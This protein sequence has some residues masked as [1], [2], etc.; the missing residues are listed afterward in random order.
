MNMLAVTIVGSL[1]MDMV[2]RVTHLPAFGETILGRDYHI[3]PGGKGANQAVAAARLGGTVHMV[4]RVGQDSNGRI[5]CSNLSAE[6]ID[7]E[8]VEVDAKSPSGVAMI[9]LDEAGQNTIVVAPG[10]NMTL[11]PENLSR[12]FERIVSM[13]ALILQLESPL[14]CV[15]EAARLGRARHAKVVLNPAPARTLPDEIYKNID[16]LVPN[17]T[18]TNLM[19]GL[20]VNTLEQAETAARQLIDMGAGEVVLTLG[21]RGALVVE[22]GK[23]ALHVPPH[24]VHVVDTTAA[25]DAFVAGLAIGLAEGLALPEATR[26]GNAAGAV[27]VTRLGAQPSMPTRADVTRL[28]ERE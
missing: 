18:E 7:V 15:L 9:T 19:T 11:T 23:N 8:F 28:L 1:N 10:A 27:A 26:L 13:D 5:L 4:G 21:K 6:G 14:E 22:H 2:V 3:N 17:E 24:T 20:P 16:V 25:G 12:P